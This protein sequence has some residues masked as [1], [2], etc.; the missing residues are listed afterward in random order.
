VE[1][2][3]TLTSEIAVHS[4]IAQQ[5]YATNRLA[6][7]RLIAVLEAVDHSHLVVRSVPGQQRL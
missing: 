5:L 3:V 2:Y 4:T 6:L 7:Q 1:E